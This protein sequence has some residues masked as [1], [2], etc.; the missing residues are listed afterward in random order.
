M[1]AKRSSLA[2]STP[3]AALDLSYVRTTNFSSFCR[4]SSETSVGQWLSIVKVSETS[5][6]TS[7]HSPIGHKISRYHPLGDTPV[8]GRATSMPSVEN[9]LFEHFV[10]LHRESK[11]G[12]TLTM[13]V[14]LSILGKFAELFNCCKEH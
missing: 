13:A 9:S 4:S 3:V 2:S 11:K 7:H 5:S 6:Q 10:T 1:R 8:I 14:A 12:A